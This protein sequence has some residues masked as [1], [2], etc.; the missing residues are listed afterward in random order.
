MFRQIVFALL[1]AGFAGGAALAQPAAYSPPRGPDGHPDFQGIWAARWLTTLERPAS[2]KTLVVTPEEGATIV[3][4]ILER[5]SHPDE[6]DPEIASPDNDGLARV[7]GE[8]RTSMI[9]EPAD[10]RLPY[11]DAGR[12]RL[13]AR[14]PPGF[15]NPEERMIGERCIVGSGRAPFLI[16][17]AGQLRRIV[18][19]PDHVVMWTEAFTDLR[20][21]P[22]AATPPPSVGPTRLG[23]SV[24]RWDGDVLVIETTDFRADDLG[25]SV[26]FSGL[27]LDPDARIVERL[28]RVSADEILYQFTVEAPGLYAKPWLAEYTFVLSD[29]P[30]FEFAC[31]EGNYAMTNMLQGAR[32]AET[33]R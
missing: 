14:T 16:A 30:I 19:T 23:H 1:A 27:M 24:A 22:V 11:S 20:I 12:A 26:P 18:Q 2:I 31:H 33:K 15:D 32:Q 10:G 17:P 21:V 9:V 4:G 29:Q 28:S 5:R 13:K 6:L 25:R 7:S 8:L 3:A